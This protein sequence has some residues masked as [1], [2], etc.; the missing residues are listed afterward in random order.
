MLLALHRT[1]VLVAIAVLLALQHSASLALLP[2]DDIFVPAYWP[3]FATREMRR[4]DYKSSDPSLPAFTSVFSY[5]L[6]S[7][8]MLYNN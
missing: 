4:F 1:V 5:D 2:V 7:A 8:S 6:G 3:L